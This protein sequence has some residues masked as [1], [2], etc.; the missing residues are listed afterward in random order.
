MPLDYTNF[1]VSKADIG[2]LTANPSGWIASGLT[3]A[4]SVGTVLDNRLG[5]AYGFLRFFG[6][7]RGGS[8]T[9][10]AVFTLEGGP[11]QTAWWPV[12]TITA[13]ATQTGHVFV[14]AWWPY[15]RVRVEASWTATAAAPS[16]T[17]SVHAYYIGGVR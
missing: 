17:G 7:S 13:T 8:V 5:A 4:N 1:P 14:S 10:S 9:A 11:D 16:G 2:A 6:S 3:T 15:L 12:A